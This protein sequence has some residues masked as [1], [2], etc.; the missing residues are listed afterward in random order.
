MKTYDRSYYDHWY[1]SRAVVIT[2][3]SRERKVHLAVSAAEFVL[4]RTIRSVLDVGCGE[5]LWRSVVKGMRPDIDYTG[6]DPSEYVVRRFGARRNIRLG[7]FASLGQ[8]GLH[9]KYDLIVCA[10]VLAYVSDSGLKRGL[11]ALRQLLRGVAYLEAYTTDDDVVG[12]LDGWQRRS[13]AE[14]RKAFDRAGLVACGLHCWVAREQVH[15][16]GELERCSD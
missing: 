5:G 15:L 1:R 11:T 14:Y 10:D 16:L 12:D 9:R 7:D 4:S 8:L 6:I 3:E 2:P 13:G